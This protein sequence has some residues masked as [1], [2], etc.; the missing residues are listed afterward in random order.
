MPILNFLQIHDLAQHSMQ[1][2]NSYKERRETL[3]YIF[4]EMEAVLKLLQYTLF[5]LGVAQSVLRLG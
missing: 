5:Y 4:L 2:I 1:G 3:S